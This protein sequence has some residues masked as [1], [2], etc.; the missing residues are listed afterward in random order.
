[1]SADSDYE[2]YRSESPLPSELRH[3]LKYLED[4]SKNKAGLRRVSGTESDV[5]LGVIRQKNRALS[6]N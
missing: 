6:D 3:Y 2:A 5:D 4:P 1:M